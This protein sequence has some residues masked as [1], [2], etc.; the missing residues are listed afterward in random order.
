MGDSKFSDSLESM[1]F[2]ANLVGAAAMPE[3]PSLVEVRHMLIDNK[4]VIE[5]KAGRG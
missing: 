2:L 3:R 5:K 4:A 1:T